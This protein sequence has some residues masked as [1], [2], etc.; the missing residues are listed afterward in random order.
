MNKNIIILLVVIVIIAGSFFYRTIFLAGEIC[1]AEQGE[2][3][4]INVVSRENQWA[5]DPP[6]IKINKCDKVTLNIFNEDD[7]DHG[8]A[9]DVFG[10][11][12]RLSPNSTTTIKFV[13]SKAGE[14]LS[15]CSVPC[16]EGHFSH[17]GTISVVEFLEDN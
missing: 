6:N 13:A 5:F 2:D 7:Y 8:F 16:G 9:I 4:E 1:T 3:V 17:K 11:N 15:Y 12:K 10:V 14:F